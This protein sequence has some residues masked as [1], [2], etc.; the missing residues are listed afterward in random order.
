MYP[1][2][3]IL[4][5]LAVLWVIPAG[6]QTCA[7]GNP[8]PLLSLNFVSYQADAFL[9][10]FNEYT[11]PSSPKKKYRTKIG[12]G[13][14]SFDLFWSQDRSCTGL[15]SQETQTFSGSTTYDKTTGA[16]TDTLTGSVDDNPC[17]ALKVTRTTRE[18]S[19]TGACAA[20]WW[21]PYDQKATAA[22]KMEFLVDEDTEED[23]ENRALPRAIIGTSNVAYRTSRA[24]DFLFG[25]RRVKYSAVFNVPCAGDYEVA[26]QLTV[27]K[28]TDPSAPV[29][30]Q[31]V[32]VTRR[33]ETGVQAFEGTLVPQEYNTDYTIES[34]EARFPC[35]NDAAGAGSFELGSV[36]VAFSLGRGA[37]GFGAGTLKVESASISPEI[38]TPGALVP[39]LADGTEA[40]RDVTGAVRQVR[41]P[42][43]LADI[44]T[45]SPAAYEVRFYA[46]AQIGAKD[47]ASKLYTVNGG[48]YVSFRV[49]NPDQPG[50]L[51]RLRVTE[52]RNGI[53]RTNDYVFEA[54]L[55]TW[56]L[57]RG[58]GVRRETEVVSIVNGDTVKVRTVRD[59]ADAVV[60]KVARTYHTFAWGQELIR[61]VIDPDGAALTTTYEFY[62]AVPV[63][64][65][66]YRRL[67]QRVDAGGAWERFT[68]A[69]NGRVVKTVRPFLNAA[70]T[71]TDDA[72][73]RVAENLYDALPDADGDGV[74]ETR[75]T[76]ITRVLGQE[77]ARTF[78]IEW[79]KPVDLGG[80]SCR[81]RTEIVATEPGAV[82]N[83]PANLVTEVLSQSSGMF[84]GRDRRVTRPD[85]T[86]TLSSYVLGAGGE[87]TT[88]RREGAP[89]QARDNVVDGRRTITA[90]DSR[91]QQV[92]ESVEDIASGLLLSR[93]IAT[94]FDSTGRVTR[95]DY[96][97]GTYVS[98]SYACCGLS[99]ERDRW[100]VTTNYVYDAL[101][102]LIEV[103]RNGVTTRTTY[104]A[105]GRVKSMSRVG[106]D[107]SEVVQE[108]NLYDGTGRLIETRDAMDRRT[109]YAENFSQASGQ[110][111]RTTTHPDGGNT[112]IVTARD[113]SR[114][115]IR[116]TAVAPRD[117]EY[118][119]DGL[120]V[121]VK[122]IAVGADVAGQPTATE[123]VKH[124][125]DFAGRPV[126]TVYPDGATVQFAY[127]QAGQLVR[128]VD[129]DGV[130]RLYAYNLLGEREITAVD[131]NANGRIDPAGSDRIVR[132]T[133]NVALKTAGVVTVTVFRT[134]TQ[135]WESEGVDLPVVASI[136]EQSVDGRSRWETVRGLTST[137]AIMVDGVG[138][139]T[140]TSTAP[141]GVK[142]TAKYA[143]ERLISKETTSA[144]GLT[145]VTVAYGYD[146]HGRLAT[147]T[148]SQTGAASYSYF[149]DDRVRT[150]T[151][152]DPDLS[153]SGPGYDP[154]TT[155]YRYDPAG[156]LET[157][158]HPDGGVVTTS[159]WPTGAVRRVTGARTFPTEYS[160]DGQ[161][162]IKTLTTW[163]NF[164]GDSGRAVTTWI[165]DAA[166]GWPVEK[167]Y[168]DSTG[169]RFSFKPS[170]RLLTRTWTRGG[171]LTTTYNYD[172]AGDLAEVRYSDQT[173]AVVAVHDR[174]G[175]IKSVQDAAGLRVLTYDASGRLEDEAYSGGIMDGLGLD[176]SFDELRRLSRVAVVSGQSTLGAASYAYDSAS[177]QSGVV[178]GQ[179]SIAYDYL[180]GS[181][182]VGGVTFRNAG[183]VRLATAKSYD[184]LNR[185][186]SVRSTFAG[187]GSFGHDYEFNA[188]NQRTRAVRE[189]QSYWNYSY[190]GLGQVTTGRKQGADGTAIPGRDFGW[191]YDDIGN[192]R[193][194]SVNGSGSNYTANSLNQYVQRTIPGVVDV[195]GAAAS[196]ATVTVAV[197][198]GSP[199]AVTRQGELY[200]KQIPVANAAGAQRVQFKVT[201]VK[202]LV[203]SAGEDAVTELSTS[204]VVP[205]SPE[206]L[207]YDADGNLTADAKW[208]YAWDAEN[209]LTA[210]ETAPQ[211]V[212]AGAP[213]QRLEFAYDGSGRRIAKKVF[214]G[215]G[216]DWVLS[217]HTLFVYDGWNLVA[218]VDALAGKAPLRT[219]V[220]GADMS[221]TRDGA[222]GVGGLLMFSDAAG[223]THFVADDG[224]GNICGTVHAVTGAETSRYDYNAFGEVIQREGPVASANPW[225]FSTRYT[226]VESGLLYF[227]YRY[228]DSG[229]GRW[230]SRDPYGEAGGANLYRM[231]DNAP[232]EWIDP[233]G[234]ALY[235]FDGTNNDGYRD[236]PTNQETNVF[237]L[238]GVYRGLKKYSTGVGTNNGLLNPVGLA[239]GFGGQERISDML[240]SAQQFI[241]DGDYTADILGFSRGAAQARAFANKVS[242]KHPCLKIRWI[243]LFDTVASE[244]L[245]NDVNI[246][247]QLGIPVDAGSVFQLTAGGER[248]A[249]TFALTSIRPGPGLPHSNPA[250][251]E[252]EIPEAVHSDVGG[253][254][255]GNR[256]LANLALVMMWQNGRSNGVPFD[257][258][259]GR[260]SNYVGTPHDSRWANDKVVEFLSGQPRVR[261]VYYHP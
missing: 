212:A 60:S 20:C 58:N 118:G 182:L 100:G 18:N 55:G 39:V 186:V 15:R 96:T 12:A 158:T 122:D 71:T 3:L 249:K 197:N 92:S 261:K 201:G 120:G 161:G 62:D 187:G 52:T 260:Y 70:P 30:R 155:T 238:Y 174:S 177:R 26:V 240:D 209:R 91:G 49:E 84:A 65:P 113:G 101:G 168:A 68:Y 250:F 66:N 171:G 143:G 94:E 80:D 184:R 246:G 76:T 23:A 121:F 225:R 180:A 119:V 175:R 192:R 69:V 11:D 109:L 123:W 124:Y 47:S 6:A 112:V 189:D 31:A 45:I 176:R 89:S 67:R 48:A 255:K 97:D 252:V 29:S 99:A 244:G 224:R 2:H 87:L 136:V 218:E 24:G 117:Y 36:Q 22:N 103:A 126:R 28:R 247:Y 156:R 172:A 243:G 254:Y 165:Y 183:D 4:S 34:V 110:T 57:I 242:A 61:E 105:E 227:G 125:T 245:P 135:L 95:M 85:G 64:D 157:V 167:R 56:T 79:S 226:D 42:Q 256:G 133:T 194:A 154:Q 78:R 206:L 257:A 159:Y 190:D 83:S 207:M 98:R 74:A 241:R 149:A 17:V 235:A 152:P 134:T 151:S 173:P 230:I 44:V 211:M 234:L 114:V 35:L 233:L 248:R 178:S 127:N 54:S 150:V 130:T 41:S 13:S 93:W 160:Y 107:G 166:R 144:A 216:A 7:P 210:M 111:T 239:F 199:Q 137:E 222:A 251:R 164:A 213:R 106:S 162:R 253:G 148:D 37:A 142:T 82:W 86:V 9:I 102:R 129:P 232:T 170:G 19:L 33:F 147:V 51:S 145:I 108:T 220:W 203:G 146:A 181:R 63:S 221:G 128:E 204:T 141:D 169:P 72:L 214:G 21:T 10:G 132:E 14:S 73:C 200:F 131:L 231:V 215:S 196:G 191:T 25:F 229:R 153:R 40:I 81:R 193:T 59:G 5:L 236:V 208:L 1:R 75:T 195:T 139:R 50:T 27:R 188:A 185:L 259:P 16:I 46:A 104:D 8:I 138:G 258:L 90:V 140:L 198:G 38:Y 77:T 53:A 205:Q 219:Y 43:A 228:L 202:N 179:N 223:A 163:Q 237:V 88:T 217:S 115:S 32:V 116:G